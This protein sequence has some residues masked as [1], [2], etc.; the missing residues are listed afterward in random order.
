M[1]LEAPVTT[2]SCP[3]EFSIRTCL[4]G[5][6]PRR[7]A[8]AGRGTSANAT[9]LSSRSLES[10]ARVTLAFAL[11]RRARQTTPGAPRARDGGDAR[12]CLTTGDDA[13]AIRNHSVPRRST[14]AR[15]VR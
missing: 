9:P 6:Q 15:R 3:V 2:A 12:L 8:G 13:D 10:L 11:F 14:G 5:G 4:L 1:P 7:G